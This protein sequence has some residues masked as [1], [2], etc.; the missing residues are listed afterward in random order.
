MFVTL[1]YH[2][3]YTEMVTHSVYGAHSDPVQPWTE[4][5]HQKHKNPQSIPMDGDYPHSFP[6]LPSQPTTPNLYSP[7]NIPSVPSTSHEQSNLDFP[8]AINSL[9]NLPGPRS[10]SPH[11]PLAGPSRIPATSTSLSAPLSPP[12]PQSSPPSAP[13]DV[14]LAQ[15]LQPES[16]DS[17]NQRGP[18]RKVTSPASNTRHGNRYYTPDEDKPFSCPHLGC[19]VRFSQQCNV[20][21][22]TTLKHPAGTPPKEVLKECN[23]CSTSSTVRMPF[24]RKDS[25]K[26]HQKS[27]LCLELWKRLYPQV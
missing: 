24:S 26:Q 5:L 17:R 13:D 23:L 9:P 27:K 22:H 25:L 15:P 10:P 8:M 6:I 4:G 18:N 2:Q 16:K 1:K 11:L 12:A 20:S 19:S 14:Q 3:A 7:S 21:R